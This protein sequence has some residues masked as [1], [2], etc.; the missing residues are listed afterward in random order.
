MS[1]KNSSRTEEGNVT[2]GVYSLAAE[3]DVAERNAT[4]GL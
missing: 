2:L 4:E 1:L 3:K